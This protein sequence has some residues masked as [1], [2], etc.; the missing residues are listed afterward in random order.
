MNKR[1]KDLIE[2]SG[3]VFQQTVS[4]DQIKKQLTGP[5]DHSEL[6]EC[7]VERLIKDVILHVESKTITETKDYDPLCCAYTTGYNQA[8]DDI[9][10][11]LI[12]QFYE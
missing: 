6:T 2:D 3:F 11:S 7:F 1:I 10:K 4:G 8:I 5:L 12:E 9:I